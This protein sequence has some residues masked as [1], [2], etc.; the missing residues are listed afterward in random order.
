MVKL[1]LNFLLHLTRGSPEG[2]G[3]AGGFYKNGHLCG[4][5][6]RRQASLPQLAS[7]RDLREDCQAL[8]AGAVTSVP[9]GEPEI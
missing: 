2:A 5:K 9:A 6:S 7:E 1:R 3:A 8:S 4:S